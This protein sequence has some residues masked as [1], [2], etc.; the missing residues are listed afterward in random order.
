MDSAQ[1]ALLGIKLETGL[2]I[3]NLEAVKHKQD[4]NVSSWVPVDGV[5][6]V[7]VLAARGI[8]LRVADPSAPTCE[9]PRLV[10]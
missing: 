3:T 2:H 8:V 1:Q 10:K 5:T 9:R 4:G 6:M 7:G